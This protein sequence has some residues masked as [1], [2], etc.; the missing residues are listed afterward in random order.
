MNGSPRWASLHAPHLPSSVSLFLFS[1][2]PLHQLSCSP[3][4][5]VRGPWLSWEGVD[6]RPSDV[7]LFTCSVAWP[8]TLQFSPASH[9]C[10]SV[11]WNSTMFC[12]SHLLA[13]GPGGVR[14][15]SV[16]AEGGLNRML[17]LAP[18]FIRPGACS[19]GELGG[20]PEAKPGDL[21]PA[22][23]ESKQWTQR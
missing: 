10:V 8:Q 2:S 20:P 3:F 11:E 14:V 21:S 9:F 7:C 16:H 12:C 6:L 23:T 1:Q 17:I 5:S 19:Q 18:A 13:L 15:V 4:S 22:F